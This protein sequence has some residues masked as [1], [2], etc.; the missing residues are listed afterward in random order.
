VHLGE[1]RLRRR[2]QPRR[3]AHEHERTDVKRRQGGRAAERLGEHDQS[4]EDRH[5]GSSSPVIRAITGSAR[6]VCSARWKQKN[7]PPVAR[8]AAGSHGERATAAA[9][10]R[11]ATC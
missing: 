8:T 6:P 5:R 1:R 4:T 2:E 10:S 3:D 9:P 7:A 11:A